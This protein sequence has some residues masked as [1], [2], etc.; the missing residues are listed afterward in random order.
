MTFSLQIKASQKPP[1][2]VVLGNSS[3]TQDSSTFL[4]AVFISVEKSQ[5]KTNAELKQRVVQ[6]RMMIL[7]ALKRS[8]FFLFLVDVTAH[9]M[10]VPTA[11]VTSSTVLSG[12]FLSLN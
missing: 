11:A 1:A 3:R 12:H 5:A 10:G 8:Q 6:P 2:S 9:L 4:E 7:P